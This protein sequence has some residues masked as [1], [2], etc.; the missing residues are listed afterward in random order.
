MAFTQKWILIVDDEQEIRDSVRELLVLTFG[1]DEIRIVEAKDG[2]EATA[3]IKNQ[4]FDCIITDMRMPK[5][6]GDAFITSI[7][8]NPYNESTPVIMLTSHPNKRILKDFRFIYLMEKP[9]LHDELTELVANQLKIGGGDRL[10]ADMVNRLVNAASSF[11]NYALKVDQVEIES[12][13]AKSAGDSMSAEYMSKVDIFDKG[14]H[15]SF[16]ILVSSDDL[17]NLASSMSNIEGAD[18][19]RM[20]YALGQSI[21]KHSMKQV[22]SSGGNF[23]ISSYA[24]KE[25]EENLVSKKGI[26]IPIKAKNVRLQILAC[27]EKSNKRAAA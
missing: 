22:K 11:L 15:N 9:F 10:A 18:L 1:E 7:R 13:K 26:I 20:A 19:S 25:V 16:S 4:M 24:G 2:M 3:K 27:G 23:K 6:E 17:K 5:K 21:L 14:I 8:Q 12:P